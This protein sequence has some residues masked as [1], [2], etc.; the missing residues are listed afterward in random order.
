MVSGKSLLFFITA[1]SALTVGKRD[2]STIFG[3]ISTIDTNFKAL[4]TSDNAPFLL[5]DLDSQDPHEPLWEMHSWGNTFQVLGWTLRV[6][7]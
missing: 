5:L 6:L 4:S 7:D 2:A 3:D 1:A